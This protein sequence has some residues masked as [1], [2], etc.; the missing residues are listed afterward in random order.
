MEIK[1][2]IKEVRTTIGITQ[3][4][5]AKRIAI[6]TS[7]ISEIEKGIKEVNERVI[8]LIAAEFNVVEHWLRTGHGTMFNENVSANVSDA[9][10]LFKSLD[11]RFQDG[12][13]KI[14]TVLAEMNEV[15]KQKD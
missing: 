14:L 9:M 2:R 15:F 5:F 6:S 7:Y 11:H 10:G 13:L 1:D 12:A 8:R 3:G 4:K